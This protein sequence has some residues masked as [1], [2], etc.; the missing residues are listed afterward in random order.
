MF[1][2]QYN[3]SRLISIYSILTPTL[4]AISLMSLVILVSNTFRG[5]KKILFQSLFFLTGLI[6]TFMYLLYN[7]KTLQNLIYS[8][9]SLDDSIKF[10]VSVI[11]I[12]V[13]YLGSAVYTG[14][15]MGGD[16]RETEGS[17]FT[18]ASCD[19]TIGMYVYVYVHVSMYY[20]CNLYFSACYR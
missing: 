5:V 20:R 9:V 4:A 17:F 12:C 7:K 18:P 14:G 3:T 6:C 13:I 11:A 15:N 16:S 19:R 10:A 2:N 1:P 8:F